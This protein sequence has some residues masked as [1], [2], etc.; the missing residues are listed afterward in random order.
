[1]LDW[2][3]VEDIRK[4]VDEGMDDEGSNLINERVRG[5]SITLKKHTYSTTKTVVQLACGP[6][7]LAES[8]S[9]S[10]IPASF[11]VASSVSAFFSPFK[12]SFCLE[13]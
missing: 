10:T 12:V 9:P 2:T 7:S 8:S 11:R 4:V 13:G 3:S 5:A 1:M 6:R